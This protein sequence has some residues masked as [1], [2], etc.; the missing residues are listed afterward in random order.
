MIFT[1]ALV[2]AEGDDHLHLLGPVGQGSVRRPQQQG[3]WA[4]PGAVRDH[5]THPLAVE[6]SLRES[7]AHE[8]ADRIRRKSLTDAANGG[9]TRWVTRIRP[10]VPLLFGYRVRAWWS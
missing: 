6:I 2:S 7:G 4:G 1:H 3:Q 5:Q 8:T 9:R 10:V